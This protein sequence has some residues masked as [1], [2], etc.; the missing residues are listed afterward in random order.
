MIIKHNDPR[1]GEQIVAVSEVDRH[2]PPVTLMSVP[3]GYK[4]VDENPPEA[5]Q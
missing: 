3:P 1:T 5:T 2:E 4:V